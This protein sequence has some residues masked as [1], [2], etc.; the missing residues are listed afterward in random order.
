MT[1]WFL[2]DFR[3]KESGSV[4]W[5]K[6]MHQLLARCGGVKQEEDNDKYA[7]LELLNIDPLGH[8]IWTWSK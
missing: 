1:L 2:Q 5:D 4:S 8:S 6:Y 3:A 7:Y